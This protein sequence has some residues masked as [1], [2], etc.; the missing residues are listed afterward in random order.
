MDPALGAY[1]EL[2]LR[3]VTPLIGRGITGV[4]VVGGSRAVE[5]GA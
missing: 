1:Q 5:V 2:P 4:V 3:D